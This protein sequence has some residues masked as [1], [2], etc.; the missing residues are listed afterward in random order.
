MQDLTE[1][2]PVRRR[3]PA[4]ILLFLLGVMVSG[5]VMLARAGD[6][7]PSD[8]Q[9]VALA[10]GLTRSS[11][12]VT[13]GEYAKDAYRQ[14]VG[15]PALD[16]AE[17]IFADFQADLGAAKPHRIELQ[18]RGNLS[19]LPEGC[20]PNEVGRVVGIATV[21]ERSGEVTPPSLEEDNNAEVRW[22]IA[23]RS[24]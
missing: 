8:G 9:A 13:F 6:R 12:G 22:L 24:G 14:T 1:P 11:D 18:F 3:W 7:Y 21:D 23:F 5:V 17:L 4:M 16:P 19:K 15:C 20:D 2:A 10:V